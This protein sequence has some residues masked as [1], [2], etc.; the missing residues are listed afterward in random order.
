MSDPDRPGRAASGSARCA[1]RGVSIIEMM[2]G[3]VVAMLVSLA[4]AGSAVVFTAS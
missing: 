1:Q 3:L 4:A 2:V